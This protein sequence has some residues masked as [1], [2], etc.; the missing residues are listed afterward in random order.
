[1]V[2]C[3]ILSISLLWIAQAADEDKIT[4]KQLSLDS[5]IEEVF[6]CGGK[7]DSILM[8]TETRTILKSENFGSSWKPLS[9]P[10]ASF[11]LSRYVRS[12]AD[13]K[14]LALIGKDGKTLYTSDCGKTLDS[15]SKDL[16]IEGFLF[17]PN[18][19]TW[20][21]ASNKVKCDSAEECFPGKTLYLTQD[22]GATWSAIAENVLMFAWGQDGL[23]SSQPIPNERIYL[24]Q[25]K[26]PDADLSK[27]TKDVDL[28]KSDDFFK[29]SV[30]LVSQGNKFLL[31]NQFILVACAVEGEQ[32]EVQLM[33]SSQ[34]HFDT[35]TKI[36]LPIRKLPQHAY[37][38]LDT[39]Q[40][41]IVIHINHYSKRSDYGSIYV[42]DSFGRV[43]S[44]SLLHNVRTMNGLSDFEKVQ[45]LEGIFIANVYDKDLYLDNLPERKTKKDTLKFQLTL[46]S[47]D[48]GGSW[49][50]VR[51]PELDHQGNRIL[52]GE[53]CF[54]NFHS[55]TSPFQQ[56]YSTENAVGIVIATGNVGRHLS[57]H[58]DEL[59]AWLSRDGGVTWQHVIKGQYVYE[60]GDHGAIILL[61]ESQKSTKSVLYSWNEGRSFEKLNL[62]FELHVEQIL[63]EPSSTSQRFLLFGSVNGT[64]GVTVS[65][66]FS[67][68]HEPA[69]KNPELAGAS[70]SDYEVWTPNTGNA[71]NCLMGR[72]VQYVRRKPLAECFNGEEFER[73]KFVENCECTDEDFECDFGY[74]REGNG[75]CRRTDVAV[76]DLECSA[77]QRVV[78]TG[79]RKVAGNTCTG[80]V[81]DRLMERVEECGDGSGLKI[82]AVFLMF[83]GV[84]GAIWYFRKHK[85]EMPKWFGGKQKDLFSRKGFTNDL[86]NPPES[87]DDDFIAGKS[88]RSEAED[89]DV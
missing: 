70:D 85:F 4:F 60:T 13:N 6:F 37:T 22:L 27:W 73:P 83:V 89:L 17:H 68:F 64:K 3:L 38:L 19:K 35:F 14:L 18:I 29:T 67:T 66:D 59:S 69:C 47:Y 48:K 76:L 10:E 49:S 62:D 40:G 32:E 23:V 16:K 42:S 81:G 74:F 24:T 78:K 55:L 86:S 87:P 61:A 15:L 50:R 46:I 33:V 82:F 11:Q 77:G 65:V 52:C 39:T 71:G 1:M 75:E 7:K 88:F 57:Y 79:Y 5:K 9:Y 56:V 80:G 30:V 63:T 41:S 8:I 45:G 12:K 36:D 34:P 51:A 25:A 2:S 26:S 21:L 44:L 31:A 58:E 72:N 28:I 43:F 20:A 53:D 84:T 54:L